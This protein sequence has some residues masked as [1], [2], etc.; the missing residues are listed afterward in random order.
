MGE[1]EIQLDV[2]Y[3]RGGGRDL[4]CD[5]YLPPDVQ[6]PAPALM[7]VH[8]G[9]WRQ[10]SKA[11]MRDF[12]L[13]AAAGGFVCVAPEYRLTPEAPWPAQIHDVKAALRWLRANAAELG[14]DPERIAL[15]GSSAGAHLV[16]LAAGTA[17]FAPFDGDGGNAGVS[18]AV[19]AVVAIYPP[20]LMFTGEERPRGGMPARALLG[21]SAEAEGARLASPVEHVSPAYPPTFLLHG[22]AD[23]TVP[24]TASMIMH[25]ALVRA[26][27]PVEMHLY[28][29]APH[30]FARAPRYLDLVMSE[31][32]NFLQRYVLEEGGEP[33][34]APAAV[35]P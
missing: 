19:K 6:T 32:V 9:G 29:E 2:T 30:G 23:K 17:D 8:G 5:I 26:G 25:E 20:T 4:Q 13:R 15:Q 21:E 11:M 31:I 7:L 14:V 22:T 3:G 28:A 10:G 12:A 24:V 33:A 18:Q 1:V 27:V 34:V 35:A 16:L